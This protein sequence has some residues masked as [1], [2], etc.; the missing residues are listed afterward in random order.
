MKLYK[1]FLSLTLVLAIA[2]PSTL[3]AQSQSIGSTKVDLAKIPGLLGYVN[4]AHEANIAKGKHL[5]LLL[6][7]GSDLVSGSQSLL[8]TQASLE[9]SGS[10]MAGV[11]S[12]LAACFLLPGKLMTLAEHRILEDPDYLQ[13]YIKIRYNPKVVEGSA[14]HPVLQRFKNL[15]PFFK[16]IE[17]GNVGKTIMKFNVERFY[18]TFN[19]STIT[20]LTKQE[21]HALIY[22]L[23]HAENPQQL[24]HPDHYSNVVQSLRKFGVGVT[25]EI[26]FQFENY[27][28]NQSHY[29]KLEIAIAKRLKAFNVNENI[30]TDPIHDAVFSVK[31]DDGFFNIR[32]DKTSERDAFLK[33]INTNKLT[34]KFEWQRLGLA[35][36]IG[37][38]VGGLLYLALSSDNE[39]VSVLEQ[40]NINHIDALAAA[41]NDPEAF[42]Q[43]LEKDIYVAA[44]FAWMHDQIIQSNRELLQLKQVADA[45]TE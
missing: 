31:L 26:I 10:L 6:S 38:A 4:Q 17:T 24:L 12:F 19:R 28:F 44:F 40:Q 36:A 2:F 23:Q 43:L 16:A 42:N 3:F 13:K 15:D 34:S 1:Q 39:P 7:D 5:P 37:A 41:D 14:T 21:V 29:P 32:R 8:S 9:I 25:K 35:V 45:I 18:S 33:K 22:C 11:L 27:A 30:F 20:P